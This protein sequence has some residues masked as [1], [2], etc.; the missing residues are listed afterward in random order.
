[1]LRQSGQ[2]D[3][4][5]ALISQSGGANRVEGEKRTSSLDSPLFFAVGNLR[6][7]PNDSGEL[8][9]SVIGMF[10][11]DG[12]RLIKLPNDQRQ[13]KVIFAEG[14]KVQ[15]PSGIL[16]L[17]VQYQSSRNGGKSMICTF[18]EVELTGQTNKASRPRKV[19]SERRA[20]VPAV[21]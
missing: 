8:L 13:V 14:Q 20:S 5:L 9:G 15:K 18:V 11:S 2:G 10:E 16:V 19:C 1:M 21:S 17:R 7:H 3:G 6:R 12:G 4:R